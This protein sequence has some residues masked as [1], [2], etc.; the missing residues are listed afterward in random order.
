[1]ETVTRDISDMDQNERSILERIVGHDLHDDQRLQIQIV[2]R[3][4]EPQ[5]NGTITTL[6]AWCNIYDGLTPDEI[7]EVSRGIVRTTTSR[8]HS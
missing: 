3:K 1:M 8:V 7:E 6:P 2:K 4:D 5:K